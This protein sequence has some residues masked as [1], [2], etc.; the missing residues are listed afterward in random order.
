MFLEDI[1]A[2]T[3]R[4]NEKS[5]DVIA[6]QRVNCEKN[7]DPIV[8]SNYSQ[9]I[10]ESSEGNSLLSL[11]EECQHSQ[12]HKEK[13]RQE[14]SKEMSEASGETEKKGKSREKKENPFTSDI[15]SAEE[16]QESMYGIPAFKYGE[17][18]GN[19]YSNH[20]GG[21]GILEREL[22]LSEG[23]ERSTDEIDRSKEEFVESPIGIYEAHAVDTVLKR[24]KINEKASPSALGGIS[25]VDESE[26]GLLE[27]MDPLV[28]QMAI[29]QTLMQES[30]Q[31]ILGE[32]KISEEKADSS[33]GEMCAAKEGQCGEENYQES[34]QNL[35][36]QMIKLITDQIRREVA[37]AHSKTVALYKEKMQALNK[38]IK[39]QTS[40]FQSELARITAE[41]EV[42]HRM[43]SKVEAL[44]SQLLAVQTS[45]DKKTKAMQEQE[46]RWIQKSIKTESTLK[47]KDALIAKKTSEVEEKAKEIAD[48]NRMLACS[49]TKTKDSPGI[50]SLQMNELRNT[51][52]ALKGEIEKMS[53]TYANSVTDTSS[54]L[55]NVSDQSRANIL[56]E[57]P[58]KESSREQA[59]TKK[60][61]DFAQKALLSAHKFT[62]M[63]S[64]EDAH[65]ES[66]PEEELLLL[67]ADE[68]EK[69]AAVI[70]K[71]EAF[72][73]KPKK[74]TA[75]SN[76]S[77]K[78]PEVVNNI[79]Y[80][81]RIKGVP[82]TTRSIPLPAL[83]KAWCSLAGIKTG[84]MGFIVQLSNKEIQL[85][86]PKKYEENLSLIAESYI[87]LGRKNASVEGPVDPLKF[88]DMPRKDLLNTL[89]GYALQLVSNVDMKH[90]DLY[91]FS[92]KVLSCKT[93]E[94]FYEK[95][96]IGIHPE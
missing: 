60:E 89:K 91:K 6:G 82:S 72:Y 29:N 32:S 81:Y 83:R 30:M 20:L 49:K 12:R 73:N 66:E 10:C 69:E 31:G 23:K 74:E 16:S 71:S 44:E 27:T 38:T 19:M 45:L 47:E 90:I 50:S 17:R 33:F 63:N 87:K 61:E 96:D 41:S 39:E 34:M 4:I 3:N 84:Y 35:Q 88:K 62:S 25:C 76:K 56:L 48:L 68:K 80:F 54:N 11:K 92:E 7:K 64:S 18:L 59:S 13:F 78:K 65:M 40:I 28:K 14:K 57:A 75:K 53:I 51:V 5:L 42:D 2:E 93:Y 26:D 79:F 85:A 70:S 22:L 94:E 8:F 43:S 58:S 86:I 52:R 77:Q 1:K 15:F 67:K 55:E 46:C 24:R 36:A 95:M 21:A 9:C 37:T